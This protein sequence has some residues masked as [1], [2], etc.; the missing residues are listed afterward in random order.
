MGDSVAGPR[1]ASD[2]RRV[3]RAGVVDVVDSEDVALGASLAPAVVSGSRSACSV[4]VGCA[5]ER[6]FISTSAA[7]VAVVSLEAVGA[8]SPWEVVAIVARC[9]CV[10]CESTGFGAGLCYADEGCSMDD[11]WMR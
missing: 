11:G 4:S 10:R 9:V 7:G 8:E 6:V 1:P 5:A 2:W 3:R